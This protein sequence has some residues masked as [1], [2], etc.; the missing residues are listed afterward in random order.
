VPSPS[1]LRRAGI[2]SQLIVERLWQLYRHD[3]S[4]FRD[5]LPDEQGL[6]PTH[7]LSTFFDPG[8]ADRTAYLIVSD[9]DRPAGFTLAYS[10]D[11]GSTSI[12][13][14]FVV[15]AGRRSG[16]GRRA[17]LELL[18]EHPGRW[19]IAFQ[20]R[21]AGAAAFWRGIAGTVTGEHWREE[22]RPVPG[23]PHIPPDNWITFDNG[24]RSGD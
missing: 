5:T 15:R 6:F 1:A 16:L 13:A 21:N 9:D 24:P 19:E 20:E 10:R 22:R 11:N 8:R 23:K 18:A 7:E 17:A 3:L 14:F 4:E 2:D 12:Y